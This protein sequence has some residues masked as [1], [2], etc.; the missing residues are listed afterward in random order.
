MNFC[1]GVC[2]RVFV[3]FY[4]DFVWFRGCFCLGS[5]REGGKEAFV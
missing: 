3:F 5:C 4:V 2:P 1:F